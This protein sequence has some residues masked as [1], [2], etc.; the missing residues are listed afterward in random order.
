MVMGPRQVP[1]LDIPTLQTERLILRPFREAD[2][3]VFCELMQDPDVIRFIGDGITPSAEDCWRAVAAWI[4]HWVMRG[5]GP[6][7]V[8]DRASGAFMG[9]A[10]I[11]FPE[12]W[13]QPE[14]GYTLGKPYWGQGYAT[15][16]VRAVR[17]WG[18]SE[19]DFPELCSLIDPLN[20]ASIRVATK[21][22]ETYRRDGA[23]RDHP[24]RI[25]VITRAE[26]EALREAG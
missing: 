5:Y 25:Y 20:T 16:A 24:L 17:D 3:A 4:G 10:G 18:F 9:R 12:G 11:H 23:L 26:W 19:R 14:L 8:T 7:A 15:E 6:W 13:P 22:G 21:V 1:E 2:A